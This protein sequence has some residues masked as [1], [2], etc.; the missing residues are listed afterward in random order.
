MGQVL[1]RATAAVI[2]CVV[3]LSSFIFGRTPTERLTT[4][5][6][7]TRGREVRRPHE[8]I[9]CGR[10]ERRRFRSQPASRIIDQVALSYR[11]RM[12]VASSSM[13]D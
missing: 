13:P 1:S 6:P 11:S 10:D 9:P 7:R 5:R 8:S 3:V 12:L 2:T 4:T